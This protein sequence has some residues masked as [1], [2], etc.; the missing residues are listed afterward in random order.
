[1]SV[2]QG[3]IFEAVRCA[4][5][6]GDWDLWLY[7]LHIEGWGKEPKENLYRV[8]CCWSNVCVTPRGVFPS[9]WCF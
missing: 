8:A 4:L 5:K 1:L 6:F 2:R 3:Y 7:L 9:R